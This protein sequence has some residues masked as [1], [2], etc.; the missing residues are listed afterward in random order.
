MLTA[1]ILASQL[2]TIQFSAL[3]A[4]QVF[5]FRQFNRDSQYDRNFKWLGWQGRRTK[6]TFSRPKIVVTSWPLK[7]APGLE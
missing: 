4:Q 1:D 2:M 7:Q 6:A 3:N 5:Q